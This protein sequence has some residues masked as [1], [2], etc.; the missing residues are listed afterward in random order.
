MIER[1]Q[2]EGRDGREGREVNPFAVGASM[3]T[4]PRIKN[5]RQFK[6]IMGEVASF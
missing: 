2:G 3:R 1:R 5:A 6:V 4:G